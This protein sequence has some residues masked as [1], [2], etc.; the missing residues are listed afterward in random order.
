MEELMTLRNYLLAGDITSALTLVD[1]MEEM[2]KDDKI[3]NIASYAVILLLHLIKQQIEQ[4]TTKSWDVSIRNSVRHINRKNKRRNAGGY[5]L[6]QYELLSSLQ[7]VFNDAIDQASLEVANDSYDS[8]QLSALVDR[9]AI[10]DKAM[11][12]IVN[13]L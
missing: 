6:T 7:E 5:Y 4:R 9:K 12:L 13:D 11:S 10:I 1:E 2:S 3:S 8:E